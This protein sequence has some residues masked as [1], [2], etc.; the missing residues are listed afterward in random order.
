MKKR[1][2]SQVVT[3]LLFVLL[4]LGA[5]LLVWNLVR[6]QITAGSSQIAATSACLKLEL[7]PVRCD[8]DTFAD[9]ADVLF[10]RGNQDPGMELTDVKLLFLLQGG[11]NLVRDAASTSI[12][13]LLE[14]KL[15]TATGLGIDAFEEDTFPDEFSVTGIL[16]D[17]DGVEHTCTETGLT[18]KC[19]ESP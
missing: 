11:T 15:D 9:T 8:F 17:A 1:G 4:A 18:V 6:S 16:T 3:T 12:P 13:D 7:E 10:K 19:L 14:T 2:L 5:V